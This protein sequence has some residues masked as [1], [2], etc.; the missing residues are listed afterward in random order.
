MWVA[1]IAARIMFVGSKLS[2]ILQF[3]R[4]HTKDVVPAMQFTMVAT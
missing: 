3:N 4:N 2:K 1:W